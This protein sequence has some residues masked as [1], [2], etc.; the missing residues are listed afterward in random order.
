M[1]IMVLDDDQV[2]LRILPI[3]LRNF[4][5]RAKG[6]TD[7][8]TFA[9]A[10]IALE[11]LYDQPGQFQ[12]IFCDLQMPGMDGVE[13]VGHLAEAGYTGRL[14]LLTGEDDKILSAVRDLAISRGLTVIGALNKPIFP[15][16]LQAVLA[17]ID[18]VEQVQAAPVPRR[19]LHDA[20][21]DHLP[22]GEV[23]AWYQPQVSLR[24]GQVLGFEALARWTD[25]EFGLVS[26]ANLPAELA[27]A[28]EIERFTGQVLHQALLQLARW[29][30]DGRP[31]SVSVNVAARI[32]S[33]AGFPDRVRD[34]AQELGAPLDRLTLEV[35][36]NEVFTQSSVQLETASRLRLK[37][38]GLSVDDFGTGYSSLATLRDFPFSELKIDRSFVTGAS[39]NPRL[40][41]MLEANLK[42]ASELK[43]RTVAEGI[44]SVE[45][46]RL[47]QGFG[48][49]AGQ[50][51]LFSPAL[52][53]EA[54]DE[55]ASSWDPLRPEFRA[56]GW[57]AS[58]SPRL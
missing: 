2:M 46:L 23:E 19:T 18:D 17:S 14:V 25:E 10:A 45:E 29:A 15:D 22:A 44:E 51:Y 4:G 8:E 28:V 30:A 31:W 3:Q 42:M 47:V 50:G 48:C 52:P 35:T 54:I 38:V 55:W 56:V 27:T 6:F 33:D 37:K 11:H 53:G 49:D 13:F 9:D 26:P 32:F 34:L 21:L 36:E 7:I 43:V 5:L 12:L 20:V 39:S 40:A 57:Q 58:A 1:K 41:T 24:T 16:A